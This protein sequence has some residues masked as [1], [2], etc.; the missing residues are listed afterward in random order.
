MSELCAVLT[1]ASAISV[2]PVMGSSIR[3]WNRPY[4]TCSSASDMSVLASDTKGTLGEPAA[5]AA[6][7]ERGDMTAAERAVARLPSVAAAATVAPLSLTSP[8]SESESDI[9]SAGAGLDTHTATGERARSDEPICTSVGQIAGVGLA[10][11]RRET[12]G[13]RCCASGQRRTAAHSDQAARER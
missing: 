13:T 11:D 4:P 2:R 5:A 9:A 6:A 3:C 10:G 7:A 8:L 1:I 12:R